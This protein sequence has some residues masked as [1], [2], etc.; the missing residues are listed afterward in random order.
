M[1]DSPLPSD[2]DVIDASGDD[3]AE[4]LQ[5]QSGRALHGMPN[6]DQMNHLQL[7]AWMKSNGLKNSFKGAS[8]AG[9]RNALQLHAKGALPDHFYSSQMLTVIR[10]QRYDALLA[11]TSLHSLANLISNEDW[12]SMH[13]KG[14]MQLQLPLTAIAKRMIRAFNLLMITELGVVAADASTYGIADEQAGYDGK[15]GWLRS[16][17][18]SPVQ[19]YVT[20]H[21]LLYAQAVGVYARCLLAKGWPDTAE[22]VQAC[23]E[24]TM[25]V[26]NSKLHLPSTRSHSFH[27]VD[28]DWR[29]IESMTIPAPQCVFAS[30]PSQVGST[31][32]YDCSF[33]NLDTPAAR[34]SILAGLGDHTPTPYAV[35]RAS[36]GDYRG[37]NSSPSFANFDYP[38]LSEGP[39]T[40]PGSLTTGS[41]LWFGHLTAHQFVQHATLSA[42]QAAGTEPVPFE[43]IRA[44]EYPTLVSRRL[45]G[46][47][48]QSH[49]EVAAAM[50]GG[51]PPHRW[52]HF[53]TGNIQSGRAAASLEPLFNPIPIS[54]H[55]TLAKCMLGLTEF[56][57]HAEAIEY[58]V[59]ASCAAQPAEAIIAAARLAVVQHDTMIVRLL[60]ECHARVRRHAAMSDVDCALLDMRQ[61]QGHHTATASGHSM[62]QAVK[63]AAVRALDDVAWQAGDEEAAEQARIAA[64]AT[65]EAGSFA[66]WQAPPSHALV[67]PPERRTRAD[68][69]DDDHD[70][71]R[72]NSGHESENDDDREDSGEPPDTP[73][74]VGNGAGGGNSNGPE[75]D[76]WVTPLLQRLTSEG[77]PY[78]TCDDADVPDR[79][80]ARAGDDDRVLGMTPHTYESLGVWQAGTGGRLAWSLR[81]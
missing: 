81:I 80:A 17:A 70:D 43:L 76:S 73:G 49:T 4:E 57:Q 79:V 64:A 48:N 75:H 9:C 32:I 55:T 2:F 37:A 58:V 38:Q 61:R 41:V 42:E 29:A 53:Y 66:P 51:L 7:R 22:N 1:A 59:A 10:R 39:V 52:A 8:I 26:Y 5:N 31:P 33:V 15:F 71:R 3:S 36:P 30:S 14:W 77:V 62:S 34:N 12:A 54:P 24:L 60:D 27:H 69:G 45:H 46:V 23:V 16:P 74:S 40:R 50:A 20:T 56:N 6:L 47:P 44:G 35:P 21:P 11:R 78:A 13:N 72:S 68:G 67:P 65:S 18:F 25:Q 28:G 63:H 19:Y